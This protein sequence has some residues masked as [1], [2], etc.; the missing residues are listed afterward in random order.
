MITKNDITILI[1]PLDWGLGHA[2]RCIPII[3]ELLKLQCNVIIATDKKQ[4]SL[5]NPE[6]PN[7]QFVELPGYEIHY[8]NKKRFFKLKIIKQV[9]KILRAII[10]EKKWLHH[11][12][13]TNEIDV[14][15]S[16]NRYGLFHPKIPCIFLTHQLTIKTGNIFIENLVQRLMYKLINHFSTC[17]IPDEMG[18]VNLAGLLSHPVSM[19]AIPAKYIGPLSRFQHHEHLKQQHKLLIVLS[20]PEPQRTF[21]EKKLLQQLKDFGD[22]VLFVRGLPGV[23][24]VLPNQKNITFHNHL[25]AIQLEQ[26]FQQ[27]EYLVSRCGY[28]TVMDICKMKIKSILIPTPGQTEQEY[29]AKH[30]QKQGFCR[31]AIQEGFNLKKELENADKFHFSFPEVDMEMYKSV[32]HDFVETLRRNKKKV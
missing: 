32:L 19:P 10:L 11:F 25:P 2:T 7:Q 30:L 20:G 8:S 28:T 9:P 4:H 6:F 24:A 21:L 13:Y 17:W 22:P 15:I 14:V 29:L 1:A 12:F 5:L 3:H 23:A 26:A 16:D 27:S 18:P 31:S